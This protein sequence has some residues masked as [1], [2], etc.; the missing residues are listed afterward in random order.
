MTRF[1]LR[2]ALGLVAVWVLMPCFQICAQPAACATN[3]PNGAALERLQ[4][5]WQGVMV[6]NESDGK[7]T[8]TVSSNSL[9]FHR[10]VNFWFETTIK[11]PAGTDPEE[12]HATIKGTTKAQA[13]SIGKVVRAIYKIEG[14]KMILVPLG[15]GGDGDEDKPKSIQA[16]VEKGLSRYE[17]EKVKSKKLNERP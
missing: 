14:A 9:H 2:G 16:A 6:G 13:D 10:D 3:Q 12:L 17:L 8:I 11:L 1:I 15:D 4:G 5:M 7:I